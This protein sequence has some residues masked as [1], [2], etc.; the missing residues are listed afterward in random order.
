M[1]MIFKTWEPW[2]E[3]VLTMKMT[4]RNLAEISKKV[5]HCPSNVSRLCNSEMFKQRFLEIMGLKAQVYNNALTYLQDKKWDLIQMYLDVAYNKAGDVPL[6]LQQSA[7]EWLLERFPEFKKEFMQQVVQIYQPT[8]LE[9]EKIRETIEDV[10]N[11]RTLLA[12]EE[13]KEDRK[14][15]PSE[16]KTESEP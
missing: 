5:N 7:R 3:T 14:E 4:G 6:R 2:H 16:G 15:V 8:V 11:L 13:K 9:I 12:T 10:K 1:G